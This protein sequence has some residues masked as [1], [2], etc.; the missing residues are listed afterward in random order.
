M[1]SSLAEILTES[2]ADTDT[3]HQAMRYVI[4]ELTEDNLTVEEMRVSLVES[5]GSEDRL[6]EALDSLRTNPDAMTEASLHVLSAAWSE[7]GH[8]DIVR[9]SVEDAKVKAP[10]IEVGIL[11]VFAMY[12]I[13]LY[14]TGGKASEKITMS[15][16]DGK[17]TY[18]KRTEYRGPGDPLAAIVRLLRL[19][20]G[21]PGSD[22]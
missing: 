20:S 21:Y 11:A 13:Y 10:V 1:T 8:R 3:L 16:E 17:V 7:P 22:D 19:S 12:G 5:V 2:S 15:Y 4:A 14:T 6:E 9:S 18:E